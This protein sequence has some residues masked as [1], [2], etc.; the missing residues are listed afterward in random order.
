MQSQKRAIIQSNIIEICQKLISHFHFRH[1][2]CAKYHDPSSNG[3]PDILLTKFHRFT[4]HRSEKGDN[5][6]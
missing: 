4:M 3:S 2:Q 5:S 6:A 1:N